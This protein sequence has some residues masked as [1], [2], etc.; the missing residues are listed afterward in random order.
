[1]V[2]EITRGALLGVKQALNEI[3]PGRDHTRSETC[4]ECWWSYRVNGKLPACCVTSCDRA[5]PTEEELSE[6]VG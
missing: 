4:N 2:D 6:H 3:D 5:G 1:M